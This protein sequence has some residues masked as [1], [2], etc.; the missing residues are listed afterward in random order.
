MRGEVGKVSV[1]TKST[2]SFPLRLW[3]GRRGTVQ[4]ATLACLPEPVCISI[5]VVA[6]DHTLPS[7]ICLRVCDGAINT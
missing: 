5:T 1:I 3:W 7:S 2:L 4:H 6:R